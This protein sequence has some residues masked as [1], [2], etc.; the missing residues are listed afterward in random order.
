MTHSGRQGAGAAADAGNPTPE[1]RNQQG[2]I[3]GRQVNQQIAYEQ[4]LDPEAT[5]DD[6][7]RETVRRFLAQTALRG[8]PIA[9]AL[10]NYRLVV[11]AGGNWRLTNAALL[12]FGRREVF[13]R[14]FGVGIHIFRVAGRKERRGFHHMAH[15]VAAYRLPV[16]SAIAEARRIV[17]SLVESGRS[18]RDDTEIPA[19]ACQEALL[20]AVAHRD[21][22]ERYR[23]IVIEFHEDRVEFR[24]PG[25]VVPPASE[26]LLREGVRSHASR[27]P[28][29]VDALVAA[30]YMRDEGEGIP[31]IH[32]EMRKKSL[33]PPGVSVEHGI[34]VLR[35]F[36]ANPD[37]ELAAEPGGGRPS[38]AFRPSPGEDES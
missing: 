24:S 20:N 16:F 22:E 26:D 34:F 28:L 13:R 21:Y 23:E 11:R 10:E 18:C 31:R 30:G 6:L 27:N 36:K 19:A 7:D 8:W 9:Q 4:R 3:L 37:G 15:V 35:L 14:R 1:G 25:G 38:R 33:P 29:L 5:L 12:L 32:D 17:G 2:A